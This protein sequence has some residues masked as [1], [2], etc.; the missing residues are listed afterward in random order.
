MEHKNIRTREDI[1]KEFEKLRYDLRFKKDI[2]KTQS[3]L[4][5]MLVDN[6]INQKKE[7]KELE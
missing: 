3:Q 2:V 1:F 7:N 4:I 5:K 6:Y